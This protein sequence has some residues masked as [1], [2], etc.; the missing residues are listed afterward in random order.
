MS[1]FSSQ[2]GYTKSTVQL[3]IGVLLLLLLR[4]RLLNDSDLSN[5]VAT[6]EIVREVEADRDPFAGPELNTHIEGGWRVLGKA[7]VLQW[8]GMCMGNDG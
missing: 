3:D 7:F 1:C 8:A 2:F 5:G 6:L 4:W